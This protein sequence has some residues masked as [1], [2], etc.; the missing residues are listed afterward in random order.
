MNLGYF[1]AAAAAPAVK[2]GGVD[3]NLR[4]I[5][6]L[7]S[8]AGE[9]GAELLLLPEM[10]VTGYTCGDL[11]SHEPLLK[12]SRRGILRLAALTGGG[13]MM[14]LG[15]P[16]DRG[17]CLYNAAFVLG[18]GR[19]LG[20]VPKTYLIN[21]REF[22]EQRWFTSGAGV[23]TSL[24][25]GKSTFPL[26]P[27]LL[28]SFPGDP[29]LTFS[30][31][32]CEDLWATIPPSSRHALA[33]ANLIFNPS[34][35]NELVGKA[36][37]R[38]NLVLQQSARILGGYLYASAGTGESTTD[39]VFGGHILAA[40]NGVL[41]GEGRRFS[42]GSELEVWDFDFQF[43][44][45]ERM[46]SSAYRQGAALENGD[47][48]R[49]VPLP[50]QGSAPHEDLYRPILR[51][52]FV[53]ADPLRREERCREILAIQSTGLATRLA[54][55][56]CSD[57]VLGLSGGLDSTLALLAA[58]QAFEELGLSKGGI[59]CYSMPGFGTTRRTRENAAKVCEQLGISLETVDIQKISMMQLQ[60]L[61]HPGTATDAAY[62]NVQARQRTAF[63][64]NKANMLGA[65]VVG[66]GDLSELALGWC[67]YSG[68][69][70]SMY[71]VN[72]GV[73]K[74][75]VSYLVNYWAESRANPQTAEVLKDIIDTPISPELLPP[76]EAGGITQKT[77]EILGPY[78]LHDFFLYNFIRC[79]FSPAKV[80]FLAQK[81][82]APGGDQSG[83]TDETILQW[84]KLF[85]RRFFSQQFKRSCL[86]DGPKVG[87]IA[88]SPRGDWRMPSDASAESWLTEV[89]TLIEGM[90]KDKP[91]ILA[92]CIHNS[93]RS[94]MAE[95]L[96]RKYG[97]NRVLPESAGIEPGT[98]NPYV[99][100]ILLEEEIDISGKTTHSV[101]DL[102]AAGR[103]FDYVIAVCDAEAAERCPLFPAEKKRL[104]WPFPDP[105]KAV[106]SDEDKRRTIRGI[107]ED[108]KARVLEFL[109]TLEE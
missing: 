62:E 108:I 105:S 73:P 99:R 101:F 88:L 87:T 107:K 74:T 6:G 89:N 70:I 41:L 51:R 9:Q 85:I 90:E 3:E 77:E 53:P 26:S 56:G 48:Y 13:P 80:F 50:F 30:V 32:V 28:F 58:V 94:Q 71:A 39:T 25:W 76:T 97:G 35:S 24:T 46:V 23:D 45:H 55:L 7:H 72:S 1:R 40:E 4:V 34:A 37:Y 12:A 92:V 44:N 31:E 104:H 61:D 29:K 106:G 16:L 47:N 68:D 84:M 103:A 93:A 54:H 64:M 15:A 60:E 86:P 102:Q 57:V 10:A 42:Q 66:T 95:E 69:H 22:Y 81:A 75:L 38:R 14:I 83:F 67:T 49:V 65:I 79:G 98:I 17:G 43:L 63:L 19:I 59:H 78:E 18:D 96:L 91:R 5:Q 8:Q 36:D 11:F 21:D 82:F 27:N 109:K 100:E 20:A 33:G 52:P 2:P